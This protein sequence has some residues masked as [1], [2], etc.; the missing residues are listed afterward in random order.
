MVVSPNQFDSHSDRID[1]EFDGEMTRRCIISRKY[2]Y[3][4]HAMR[5]EL[6]DDEMSKFSGHGSDHGEASKLLDRLGHS[7]LSDIYDDLRNK[8]NK[9][10]YDIDENIGEFEKDM[11][12]ADVREFISKSSE[13][14]IL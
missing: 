8:R 1:E 7:D 10:D 6:A 12:L 2:Y 3:I 14:D 11:F 5:S 13:R 4:F 9:A